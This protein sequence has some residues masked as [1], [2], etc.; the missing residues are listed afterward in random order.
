MMDQLLI[1][2]CGLGLSSLLGSSVGLVVKRIPHNW[3]DIFLGF[4]AGMM[5][6][7]AIVCLIYPAVQSVDMSGWWQIVVG[8]ALGVLLIGV[9]DK[10]TPHLHH[11]SG[12]DEEERHRNASSLNK[13]F[14]FVLAIAIHKLP[15]GMATG[16][17]YNGEEGN[18]IA[19]TITIALQNIPEGMVIVT[20]L[21]MAGVK[22]FNTMMI[23][24]FVALLEVAGVFIGFFVGDISSAMLPVMLS[25]AGGAMLY[26]I[27]DEMIPETH[28]H[29]FQREATYAFVAGVVGM[30][31][32]ES[33]I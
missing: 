1:C 18:A 9:L 14:L 8:V 28:S 10:I 11:L 24:L 33:A 17:S 5:L 13:T 12:M 32:I 6:A 22:F 16:I 3:N 7:A 20:P 29:G 23:A 4:C 19:I 2:A 26:V 15:E 27:S 21:L 31:L 30:L 25:L